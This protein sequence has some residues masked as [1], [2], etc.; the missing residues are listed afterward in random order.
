MPA[1]YAA[2]SDAELVRAYAERVC[3][4]RI[5]SFDD[6]DRCGGVF[7][8]LVENINRDWVLMREAHVGSL[9]SPLTSDSDLFLGVDAMTKFGWSIG[10]RYGSVQKF[11][12]VLFKRRATMYEYWHLDRRRAVMIA[13]LLAC[14]GKCR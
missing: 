7:P 3:G 4:W 5:V 11:W 1:D 12:T 14:E 13:A 6:E 8:R 10:I 2:M 9:F